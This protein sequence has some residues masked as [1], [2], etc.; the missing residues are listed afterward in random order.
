MPVPSKEKT[1][2]QKSVSELLPIPKSYGE[3]KKTKHT[4]KYLN[5]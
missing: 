1:F 4:K 5:A 3:S 2:P